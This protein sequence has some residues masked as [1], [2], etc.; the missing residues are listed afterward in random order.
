MMIVSDYQSNTSTNYRSLYGS[1]VATSEGERSVGTN[2][3]AKRST[4]QKEVAEARSWTQKVPE[5]KN[6]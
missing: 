5:R 4:D 2:K 1:I 3:R 6:V